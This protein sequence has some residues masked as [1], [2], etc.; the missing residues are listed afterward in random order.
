MGERSGAP[1][2]SA[3]HQS[4]FRNLRLRFN[5]RSQ[6]SQLTVTHPIRLERP[7]H[8]LRNPVL[9]PRLFAAQRPGWPRRQPYAAPNAASSSNICDFLRRYGFQLHGLDLLGPRAIVNDRRALAV[10]E[11]PGD[12]SQPFLPSGPFFHTYQT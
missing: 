11:A 1:R 10:A 12:K 6:M 5:Y 9:L 2:A 4:S 3:L 8:K 7:D